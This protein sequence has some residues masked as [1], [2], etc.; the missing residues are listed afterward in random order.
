[1]NGKRIATRAVL[2]AVG[3]MTTLVLAAGPAPATL[4]P[5]SS[6]TTNTTVTLT[7]ETR[8]SLAV[9]AAASASG[10]A[11]VKVL[12]GRANVLASGNAK[13]AADAQL[14]AAYS[15][16]AAVGTVV[17]VTA[18][19]PD[20]WMR[21]R[22]GV[23]HR[24]DLGYRRGHGRIRRREYRRA[25][26]REQRRPG[27]GGQRRRVCPGQGQRKPDRVTLQGVGA[28]AFRSGPPASL[29]SA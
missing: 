21:R 23:G 24:C 9:V 18:A 27:R 5:L 4:A 22:V 12:G 1:M 15:L 19:P 11:D 20:R 7:G 16:R 14:S 3:G 2:A 25:V 17:A 26:L 10:R 13:V 28:R 8:A 29:P 6:V